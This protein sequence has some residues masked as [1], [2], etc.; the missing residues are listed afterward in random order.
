[1]NSIILY[2]EN[3]KFE[4]LNRKRDTYKKKRYVGGSAKNRLRNPSTYGLASEQTSTTSFSDS[5]IPFCDSTFP[6]VWEAGRQAV[7]PEV[8]VKTDPEDF[9]D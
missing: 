9:Q 8:H 3:W 4:I 5:A 2:F 6:I 1:M 7:T